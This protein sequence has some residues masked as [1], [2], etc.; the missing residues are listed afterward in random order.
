MLHGLASIA[1]WAIARI[2]FVNGVEVGTE[3]DLACTH[4]RNDRADYPV[5]ACL[6][7]EQSFSDRTPSLYRSLP[8]SA[9]SLRDVLFVSHYPAE[10]GFSSGHEDSS[11]VRFRKRFVICG[12]KD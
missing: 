6:Q 8:Y 7:G 3:A 5:Y 9:F 10:N 11:A 12:A 4:L 2:C 1:V